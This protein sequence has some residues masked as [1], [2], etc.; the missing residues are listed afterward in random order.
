M[1]VTRLPKETG[2]SA[3]YDL[4]PARPPA[5]PLEHKTTADWLVIGAGFAGLAAARR[6]SQHHPD[7]RIVI[8]EALRVGE[9]PVGRNSGFMID[10]PHNL[11]S[12]NYSGGLALDRAQISHNRAAI[13]F[14]L[15]AAEEYAMS[16]ET[17]SRSGKINGAA[18]AQ[19]LKHNAD[20]STHLD[21]MGEDHSMLDAGDMRDVTGSEYYCGGLY[22]P[23]TAMLH[24]VLYARGMA[25]GLRSCN[26]ALHECSPVTGIQREGAAWTVATPMGQ[27][28]APKVILAVNGH[29]ESFGL[30]RRRLVH[31]M[32]YG[33]MTRALSEAEASRLGG[34]DLW[35]ITP[36]DPM[37]TTVRR[38]SGPSGPRILVRNR[39]TYEPSMEIARS[40]LDRISRS[41]DRS[42]RA[43]FPMLADVSME[44]CW[45]G[46]LCLSLNNAPAFGETDQGLIAACCQN[47]LGAA[48]GTLS[49]MAAAD[50]AMGFKTDIVRYL[51]GEP[52]PRRLPPEPIATIGAKVRIAWGERSAGP[53]L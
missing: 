3:W 47:G 36:A 43:R 25:E 10:L 41:H 52:Q 13:A 6:L 19:G 21:R 4:V 16:D 11:A 44:H 14:A 12:D 18:T 34:E 46:R 5:S 42:F 49:G 35:G 29:A 40:Q 24:P 48:K 27:V 2:T 37:G 28:S 53:E 22:T 23:G 17:I 26:V 8:L 9:G 20:Y 45:S 1:K 33:S 39:C 32:L 51:A 50:L 31:V 15:E 30:F 7:D 38:I